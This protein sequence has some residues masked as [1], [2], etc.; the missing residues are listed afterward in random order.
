MD[1]SPEGPP[2]PHA[3]YISVDGLRTD[4]DMQ[5]LEALVIGGAG[6]TC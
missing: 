6:A 2:M 5:N 1:R 3:I 4:D